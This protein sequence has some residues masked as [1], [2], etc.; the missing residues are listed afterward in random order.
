MGGTCCGSTERDL[1]STEMDPTWPTWP[2]PSNGNDFL[3][4]RTIDFHYVP[5]DPDLVSLD[6][7]EGWA[8]PCDLYGV[9][10]MRFEE[11]QAARMITGIENTE[12]K[13][14]VP[15]GAILE[16][17]KAPGDEPEAVCEVLLS[18]YWRCKNPGAGDANKPT[19]GSGSGGAGDR[20]GFANY[21]LRGD[22]FVV[23]A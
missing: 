17:I 3:P 20:S 15:E 18:S 8:T 14:Y 2:M 23:H 1:Q 19:P 22:G 7:L 16:V 6:L 5:N 9:D 10:M 4:D 13:F 12:E 11:G 21:H